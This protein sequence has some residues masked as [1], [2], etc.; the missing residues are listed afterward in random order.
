MDD[1]IIPAPDN[2]KI[3]ALKRALSDRFH[4]ANMR[5]FVNYLGMVISRDRANRK[6]SLSQTAYFEKILKDHH[7][8]DSRPMDTLM[9]TDSSLQ[10]AEEGYQASQ[11]LRHHYQSAA[12][13]LMYVTLGTRPDIA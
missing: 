2:T 4:I 12:G 3:S 6:L 13:S 11:E 9:A 7:M 5:P 8:L 10:K 1:L